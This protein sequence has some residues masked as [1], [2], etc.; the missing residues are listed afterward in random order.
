MAIKYADQID[1]LD[2]VITD[3]IG[4]VT[5]TGHDDNDDLVILWDEDG[6]GHSF[7]PSDKLEVK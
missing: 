3:S 1:H 4:R 7:D 2:T 6:L 5:E